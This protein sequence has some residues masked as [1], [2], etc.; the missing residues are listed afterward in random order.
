MR[1]HVVIISTRLT[2]NKA[3]IDSLIKMCLFVRKDDC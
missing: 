1:F 3:E 2:H